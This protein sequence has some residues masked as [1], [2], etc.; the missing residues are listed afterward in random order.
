M[1][2]MIVMRVVI[3]A[4]AVVL[5]IAFIVRGD[6]VIGALILVIALSRAAMMLMMTKRRQEARAAI[7]ERRRLER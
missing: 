1:R 5:A 4:L 3:S 6:Y 2:G 7:R